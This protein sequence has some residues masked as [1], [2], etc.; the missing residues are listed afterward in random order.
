MAF[1]G[2][3]ELPFRFRQHVGYLTE[4]E[5][6][7][8][9]PDNPVEPG[10]VLGVVEPVPSGQPPRGPEQPHLVVMVQRPDRQPGRFCQRASLPG[11][12]GLVLRVRPDHV[13]TLEPDPT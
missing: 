13:P 11:L 6:E 1:D 3:R 12:S 7:L 10:D 5:A 9:Q 8:A 2:G 4:R